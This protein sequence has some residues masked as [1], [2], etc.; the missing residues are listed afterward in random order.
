MNEYFLFR[1][2]GH[3]AVAICALLVSASAIAA[4]VPANAEVVPLHSGVN[5]VPFGTG[6]DAGM[7]ILAH[8]ENFNAHSFQ[9]ASFYLRTSAQNSNPQEWQIVPFR[10][11]LKT[12]NYD[13]FLRVGGGA[14]CQTLSF[15]LLTDRKA[16]ATY[17]VIAE[18]EFGT[19]FG[20]RNSVT[21]TWF[22]LTRGDGLPGTPTAF[23][24]PFQTDKTREPYCDV[25]RAIKTVLHLDGAMMPK[26]GSLDE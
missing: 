22:K 17:V 5:E 14:D 1:L 15:R 11:D 6:A 3:S 13:Y 19:S 16:N 25:D 7:V 8:R 10:M 26:E 21:F 2:L 23:F 18:R 12:E 4:G 24:E 20:D 9:M